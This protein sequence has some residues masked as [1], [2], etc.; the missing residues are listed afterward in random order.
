MADIE[1]T[2]TLLVVNV[3]GID[4]FLALKSRLEVPLAHVAGVELRPEAARDW[5]HGFRMPGTQ[6]PGVVTAG[7]FY[8]CGECVFW[9]VHDPDKTI[10]IQLRDEYYTRLVIQVDNPEA[11]AAA[12]ERAISTGVAS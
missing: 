12:I 9:D 5:W 10:A 3:T 4:R 2:Q 1:I 11:T 7:S 6:L 8:Q